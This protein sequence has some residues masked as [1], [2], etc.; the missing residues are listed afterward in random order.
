M[1]APIVALA[2]GTWRWPEVFGS[3]RYHLWT[4]AASGWPVIYVEPVRSPIR[5]GKIWSAPDRPF[6]VVTPSVG[7]PFG[8]RLTPNLH[9]ARA[10]RTVAN[11]SLARAAAKAAK[12]L[13]L[14]PQHIWLGSPWHQAQQVRA[15]TGAG[16][17]SVLHIYD[18]L[19][20][21]PLLAMWQRELLT[22]WEA[23]AMDDADATLCSSQ[24]QFEDRQAIG[25]TVVHLPNGIPDSFLDPPSSAPV[26]MLER[27]R[28]LPRP[29]YVY[30]GVA[31]L[32]LDHAYFTA[33]VRCVRVAGGSVIFLGNVDRNRSPEIASLLASG[34]PVHSFGSVPHS[35]LPALLAES[36][37]CLHAH[38]SSPFT[39]GMAPEKI[40]EYLAAGKP[41]VARRTRELGLRFGSPDAEMIHLTDTPEAFAEASLAA[42]MA[43][44]D[45]T[46][47]A[48]RRAE[49][50]RYTWTAVSRQL[51]KVLIR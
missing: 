3:P 24:S 20:H 35:H 49:A 4:L 12:R 10:W 16:G 13:K 19:A 22:S 36:D 41:I 31:D 18:E 48:R 30:S 15:A 9:S 38:V 50:A 21:S 27:L 7:I 23:D 34:G 32:R 33:L 29:R 11:W 45:P 37:C 40:N 42:A 5:Q 46:V 39:D 51:V 1:T 43:P 28:S 17:K 14:Q 47:V 44:T 8:L 26:P 2:A 25:R 6:H